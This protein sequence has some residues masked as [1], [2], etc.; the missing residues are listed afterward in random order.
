MCELYSICKAYRFKMPCFLNCNMLTVRTILIIM[1]LYVCIEVSVLKQSFWKTIS[2]CNTEN[3][4]V[5]Y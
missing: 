1:T 5:L 2:E 4:H 3:N